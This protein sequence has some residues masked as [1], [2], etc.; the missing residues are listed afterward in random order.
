ML[1]DLICRPRL[2]SYS[3]TIRQLAWVAQKIRIGNLKFQS[4]Y[5][6]GIGHKRQFIIHHMLRPTGYHDTV[7]GPLGAQK[8][9]PWVTEGIAIFM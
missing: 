9:P 7:C 3:P 2:R 1:R 8:G 5:S 4:M 6:Y